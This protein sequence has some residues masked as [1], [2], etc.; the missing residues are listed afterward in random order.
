MVGPDYIITSALEKMVAEVTRDRRCID[1]RST[2]ENRTEPRKKAPELCVV[3]PDCVRFVIWYATAESNE[4]IG[5]A[6]S[7]LTNLTGAA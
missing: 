4:L 7:F 1:V 2:W 3:C 5:G 6:E